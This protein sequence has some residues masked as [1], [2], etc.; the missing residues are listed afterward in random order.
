MSFANWKKSYELGLRDIDKQHKRLLELV[1]KAY[2]A[3][4][5]N[6]EEKVRELLNDMVEFTRIHFNTE[7][8]YFEEFGYENSEPHIEQHNK[9]TLKALNLYDKFNSGEV[10]VAKELLEFLKEW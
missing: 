3:Y 5:S 6:S 1:N 8:R 2:E 7:E 9:L 4:K 10:R